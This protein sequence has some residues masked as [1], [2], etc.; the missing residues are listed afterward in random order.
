MT[1]S[2]P[3]LFWQI[4]KTTSAANFKHHWTK[5]ILP[6]TLHLSPRRGRLKGH[7]FLSTTIFF[8]LLLQEGSKP[9]YCKM[10]K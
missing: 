3:S 4:P 5:L 6:G 8:K 7:G 10:L 9:S 2:T 1:C